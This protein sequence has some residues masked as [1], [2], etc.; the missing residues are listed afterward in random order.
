MEQDLT[1]TVTDADATPSRTFRLLH[2]FLLRYFHPFLFS[3]WY[4]LSARF[5]RTAATKRSP[6][7]GADDKDTIDQLPS[8]LNT[9]LPSSLNTTMQLLL[10]LSPP[11]RRILPTLPSLTHTGGIHAGGVLR[12]YPTG[13]SGSGLGRN[14]AVT[15]WLNGCQRR[16]RAVQ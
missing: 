1:R 4:S 15:R 10:S 16:C 12:V 7:R 13:I 3:S 6:V 14:S 11:V 8:S 5:N 9:T 2:F